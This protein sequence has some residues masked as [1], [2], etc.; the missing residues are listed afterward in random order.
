MCVSVKKRKMWGGGG[1]QGD[2]ER[3]IETDNWMGSGTNTYNFKLS[4]VRAT[5]PGSLRNLLK[6]DTGS[7]TEI[8]EVAH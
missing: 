3:C 4:W 7:Y 2:S 1:E 5:H 6:V 8:V